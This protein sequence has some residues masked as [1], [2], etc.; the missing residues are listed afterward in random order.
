MFENYKMMSAEEQS[1]VKATH[2]AVRALIG[3]HGRYGNLAWG[4]VR[5]FPYK[6]IERTTR[7]DNKPDPKYLTYVIGKAVP[8]FAEVPKSGNGWEM[9][10]SPVIE[11]WLADPVG[12]IEAP[13]RKKLTPGEARALHEGRKVA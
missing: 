10:A 1:A 6:R 9:T 7:E 13:V 4:F 8:S 12:A 3:Q 2:K 11:A 5:G